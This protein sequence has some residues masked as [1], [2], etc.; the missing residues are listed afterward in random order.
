MGRTQM[1][2]KHQKRVAAKPSVVQISETFM[3]THRMLC[4]ILLWVRK[5]A[6][7]MKSIVTAAAA[8]R[9]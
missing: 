7:L 2:V 4:K 5:R 9:I 1:D 3:L 6:V 8:D